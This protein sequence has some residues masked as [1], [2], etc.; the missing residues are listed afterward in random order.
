M[1]F[2]FVHTNDLIKKEKKNSCAKIK[3]K[4]EKTPNES[5][6]THIQCIYYLK[7]KSHINMY[8]QRIDSVNRND[9]A[10]QQ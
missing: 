4:R 3:K 8:I 10:T 7:T 6:N 1:L 9:T 2:F 5:L